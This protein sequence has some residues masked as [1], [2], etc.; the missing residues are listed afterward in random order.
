MRKLAVI[1]ALALLV[2]IAYAQTKTTTEDQLEAKVKAE[3]SKIDARLKLTTDQKT[4]LKTLLNEQMDQ[5][6]VIDAEWAAKD[7]AIRAEY[8][9]KMRAVLTTKQQAEWDKMK[10]EYKGRLQ[11]ALDAAE[12][13]QAT[14]ASQPAGK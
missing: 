11:A 9:A 14:Q 10:E 13:A 7:A 4:Q 2:P 1:L 8:R 3:L 12:K 6:D 5:M